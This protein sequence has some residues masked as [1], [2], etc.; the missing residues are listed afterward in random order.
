MP[1]SKRMDEIGARLAAIIAADARLDDNLAETPT[2]YDSPPKP[3]IGQPDYRVYVDWATGN[4]VLSDP[5]PRTAMTFQRFEHLITVWLVV[6]NLD[7]QTAYWDYGKLLY[8]LVRIL[9]DETDDDG[10]W[11]AG[12]VVRMNHSAAHP[13]LPATGD[14]GLRMGNLEFLMVQ[15]LTL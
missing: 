10:Y 14:V 5:Q 11:F 8:N 6:Y 9:G 7:P 1:N 2:V 3:E 4:S 13:N 12:R 15:E